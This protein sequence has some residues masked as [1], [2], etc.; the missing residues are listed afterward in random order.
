MVYITLFCGELIDKYYLK[1]MQIEKDLWGVLEFYKS[2]CQYS[3]Y[4][5]CLMDNH[6]HLLIK[7][8]KEEIGH[9]MKRIGVSYVI[10]H[11]RKYKRSGHLF[12]DRFKSEIVE[13][14]EYL[15]TVLRY[16]HQN[17]AKSG[18]AG[19]IE[20]YNWN[21]YKEYISSN[22][23]VDVDFILDVFSTDREKAM[24]EFKIFMNEK[25]SDRCLEFDL[26]TKR[27]DQEVKAIIQERA[28]IT[29]PTDLQNME[30]V[31]RDELLR[32][33]KEQEGVS[34]RQIAR[35]TGLSQTVIARA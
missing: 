7:E 15:L 9:I 27:T 12:Q 33:I 11:N 34:T 24:R 28:N 35:L 19:S 3:L 29:I 10:W 6:I 21:S 2:V 14:D 25:T 23:M 26:T 18:Q 1:M 31:K 13:S 32:K 22:R 17:P 30:K 5:Y 16:I 20:G 8:G 4:G